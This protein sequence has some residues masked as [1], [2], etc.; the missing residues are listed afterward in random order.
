MTTAGATTPGTATWATEPGA[1]PGA[2]GRAAGQAASAAVGAGTEVAAT[3]VAALVVAV[4]RT[5]GSSAS[6]R[7][8]AP[9]PSSDW[10]FRT[11]DPQS[12]PALQAAGDL[13]RGARTRFRVL[14]HLLLGDAE[15]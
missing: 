13:A 10:I 5:T 2:S 12:V 6:R 14:T 1:T 8:H 7:G 4:V 15:A 11:H 3:A 9:R